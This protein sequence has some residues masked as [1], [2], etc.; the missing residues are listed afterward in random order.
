MAATLTKDTPIKKVLDEPGLYLSCRTGPRHDWD[1]IPVTKRPSFGVAIWWRC[2]KCHTL[3]KYI[4]NQ[5]TGDVLARW[6]NHPSD[7]VKLPRKNS[8]AMI[9]ACCT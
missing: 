7:W 3:R 4:Y 5:F 2:T 8:P 9:C 1:E 6:Y